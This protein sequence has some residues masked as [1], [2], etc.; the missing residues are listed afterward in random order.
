MTRRAT[1]H[2][3]SA[4]PGPVVARDCTAAMT[5]PLQD[6]RVTDTA[7]EKSDRYLTPA[8]LRRAL[9]TAE[10]YVARKT[11]PNHD[12]L[13]DDR[14][15]VFRGEF[16]GVPLDVVFSVEDESVVVITQ[17]SQH[18]DSLRGRFYERVGTTAGDAVRTVQD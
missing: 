14:Q 18:A 8:Q 9:R 13:Y 10:G 15:F 17:M 2:F 3:L 5:E 4:A 1:W 16:E 6:V 7:A 12:D 11:S